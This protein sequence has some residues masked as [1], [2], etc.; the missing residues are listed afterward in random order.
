MCMQY[1]STKSGD[2]LTG[3]DEYIT[4]M[5][6]GQKSIYYVTAETDA[7]AA[8]SPFVESLGKKG[9]EVCVTAAVAHVQRFCFPSL[10]VAEREVLGR[11]IV[12]VQL[13]HRMIYVH[14]SFAARL[15][16]GFLP[17]VLPFTLQIELRRNHCGLPGEEI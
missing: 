8:N 5:K 13:C 7:L 16:F 4:R 1:K 3:L 11:T 14:S 10:T 12:M 9:I 6:E 2:V 17:S 15:L